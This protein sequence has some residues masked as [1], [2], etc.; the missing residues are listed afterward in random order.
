MRNA[1][2]ASLKCKM[3]NDPPTAHAVPPPFQ[4]GQQNGGSLRSKIIRF[5][6]DIKTT[7]YPPI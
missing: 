6:R 7:I 3:Q 2:G 1:R 5:D 4:G